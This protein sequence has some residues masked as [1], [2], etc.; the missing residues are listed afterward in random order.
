MIAVALFVIVAVIALSAILSSNLSYKKTEDMR[1]VTDNLTFTMEDMSRNIKLGYNYSCNPGDNGVNGQV[2]DCR[3]VPSDQT[4]ETGDVYS[5]QTS[6]AFVPYGIGMAPG[7][8][9][10]PIT[11]QGYILCP[12][13]GVT[14]SDGTTQAGVM[15][16]VENDI[17]GISSFCNGSHPSGVIQLTD[18]RVH[19]DY[20]RSGFFVFNTDPTDN[21]QPFVTMVIVGE[22]VSKDIITPFAIQTSVTQRQFGN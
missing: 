17:T 9:N 8:Q 2:Q 18:D 4:L 5:P 10:D 7:A 3:Y 14:L 1:A 13:S 19:L 12:A 22:I 15:Y 16:K 20:N 6:I 21:R 11:M